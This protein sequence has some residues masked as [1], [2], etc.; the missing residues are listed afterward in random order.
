MLLRGLAFCEDAE[1]DMATAPSKTGEE[2]PEGRTRT[3]SSISDRT[4]A[5]IASTKSAVDFAF[6]RIGDLPFGTFVTFAAILFA[7]TAFTDVM[8][9]IVVTR[10]RALDQFFFPPW[11]EVMNILWMAVQIL[12]LGDLLYVFLRYYRPR[13]RD[14][15]RPKIEKSSVRQPKAW[16]CCV[17]SLR[18][19]MTPRGYL[20][21]LSLLL[22]MN[23]LLFYKGL[24]RPVLTPSRLDGYNVTDLLVAGDWPRGSGLEVDLLSWEVLRYNGSVATPFTPQFLIT[25]QECYGA[26]SGEYKILG[27]LRGGPGGVPEEFPKQAYCEALVGTMMAGS[28]GKPHSEN[29]KAWQHDEDTWDEAIEFAVRLFGSLAGIVADQS[30]GTNTLLSMVGFSFLKDMTDVF[31]MFMLTFADV[32]QMHEGR[33]QLIVNADVQGYQWSYHDLVFVWIW[34]GMMIVL[35]RALAVIGFTPFVY[36]FQVAGSSLSPAQLRMPIDAFFSMFFIEIPFLTLRWIAWRH[37][38]VPVSVMAVKN[39]LGIYEDLYMLG[40]VRGFGPGE[41]PRGVRLCCSRKAGAEKEEPSEAVE[42][43][44]IDDE[45]AARTDGPAGS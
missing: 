42:G 11:V 8:L 33:P 6:P 19:T 5:A 44:V 34:V 13:E 32:D 29:Q 4:S 36:L 37:Y 15:D 23:A 30:E 28:F 14:S 26:T 9:C 24:G 41:K 18:A 22:P 2:P 1:L 12:L 45:E 39:I 16:V 40:I 3:G 35:L 7:F 17:R 21:M 43:V 38:G 25:S 27:R 31:D 10:A 20:L